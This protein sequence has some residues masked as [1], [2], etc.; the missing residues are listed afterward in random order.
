MYLDL[1]KLETE[2]L[3]SRNPGHCTGNWRQYFMGLAATPDV[4]IV[5]HLSIVD[6]LRNCK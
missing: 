6:E 3:F 1:P 2:T 4:A 5:A